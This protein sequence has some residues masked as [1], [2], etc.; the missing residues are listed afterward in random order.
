MSGPSGVG[1]C[2]AQM[3][4]DCEWIDCPQLRDGEPERSR[5]HCPLDKDDPEL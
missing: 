5:R 4:G 2:H 1:G 3:D